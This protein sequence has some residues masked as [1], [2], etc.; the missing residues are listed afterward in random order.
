MADRVFV[1]EPIIIMILIVI[2]VLIGIVSYGLENNFTS[3][4]LDSRLIFK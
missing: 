2:M 3:T 1:D 4:Q